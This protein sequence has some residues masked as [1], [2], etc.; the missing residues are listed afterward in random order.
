MSAH[1]LRVPLT[2][3][4]GEPPPHRRAARRWASGPAAAWGRAPVA[5]R[6]CRNSSAPGFSPGS[7]WQIFCPGGPARR[8]LWPCAPITAKKG[9][10]GRAGARLIPGMGTPWL[11]AR[12]VGFGVGLLAPPLPSW[13]CSPR[14]LSR[15]TGKRPRQRLLPGGKGPRRTRWASSEPARPGSC[16]GNGAL[17]GARGAQLQFPLELPQTGGF[18]SQGRGSGGAGG[19]GGEPW[20]SLCPCAIGDAAARL[21]LRLDPN[22]SL[23]TLPANGLRSWKWERAR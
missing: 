21:V 17:R 14:P 6:R 16:E 8:R 23:G 20:G 11:A 4:H 10:E 12:E 1:P 2:S 3:W 15:S 18:A 22:L 9:V 5:R 13:A 19:D 7:R